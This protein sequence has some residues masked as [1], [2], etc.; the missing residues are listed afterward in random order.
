MFTRRTASRRRTLRH[1]AL[2]TALTA[3]AALTLGGCGGVG[4]DLRGS[5]GLGRGGDDHTLTVW[6]FETKGSA[7]YDGF[8]TAVRVFERDH[9]GIRVEVVT[10]GFDS[11]RRNAK[12]LLTGDD[13]PDVMEINK[14]SS[15]GGQLAAQGLLTD[16][17]PQVRARG[18][19]DVVTGSM[20]NLARYDKDGIAGS[21]RWFGVP[22][23]GQQFTFFY[24]KDLFAK[25]GVPVPRDT[26]SL[27][28]ALRA[29]TAKGQVPISS[30]AGEFG[31]LQ[32]WYQ[33]VVA[34]ADRAQVD[35][36]LFLRGRTDFTKP[37]W[38]TAG[39]ELVRWLRAGYLG[40]KL[41]GLTQNQMETAFLAGKYP[42]MADNSPVFS[43]V[44]QSADFDWGTFA[45][46]G[47]QL[48]EGLTGQLLS[49]P[50]RARHKDLAYDFITDVLAKPAQDTVGR[51]GGLPLRSDPAVIT[52][53]RTRRFTAQF[54]AL[55]KRDAFAYFPDYPVTGLLEF[56]E[57][58][59]QGLASGNV[60]ASRFDHDLQAFYDDGRA[61]LGR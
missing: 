28:S 23:S 2:A 50:A 46:P 21:G 41:G 42:L 59:L 40:T 1:G 20:Q 15:D 32:L 5:L 44:G 17:T 18:W 6:Q 56:L 60:S 58:E 31:L 61:R 35:N 7:A 55:K 27:M 29:F 57:S 47:A 53:P 39:R 36:Y 11:I 33:F 51:E 9:P 54:D 52:D 37:P 16:L 26:A 34:H 12:M 13:V 22:T 48:T 10:Q 14:G 25:A 19:D 49:V 38:S 43:T 8:R 3:L 24:N 45:F 30:N 4:S